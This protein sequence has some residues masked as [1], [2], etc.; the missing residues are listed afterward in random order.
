MI[1]K[2]QLD[3]DDIVY[4]VCPSCGKEAIRFDKDTKQYY[5]I[6]CDVRFDKSLKR[7]NLDSV[8]VLMDLSSK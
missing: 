5:C 8:N 2:E 3:Q 6:R 1:T 7:L 4:M